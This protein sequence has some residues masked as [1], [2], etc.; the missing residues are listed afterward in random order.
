[1]DRVDGAHAALVRGPQL[2]AMN[3]LLL[4]FVPD[5]G[6]H[7]RRSHCRQSAP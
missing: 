2:P 7:S 4:R 6:V 5:K 3:F 1:M